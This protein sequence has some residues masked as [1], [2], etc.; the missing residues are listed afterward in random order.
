[1]EEALQVKNN[2]NKNKNK[3]LFFITVSKL[4]N[5]T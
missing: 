2:D 3:T 4:K 1:M 5:L